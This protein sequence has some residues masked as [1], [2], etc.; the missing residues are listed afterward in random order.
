MSNCFLSLHVLTF[1]II[2]IMSHNDKS[3]RKIDCLDILLS[4]INL[5]KDYSLENT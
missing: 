4:E 2:W 1:D 5:E 3:F